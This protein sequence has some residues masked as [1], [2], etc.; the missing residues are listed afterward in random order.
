M[1]V[2]DLALKRVETSPKMVLYLGSFQR[3]SICFH[4][5]PGFVPH[6]PQGVEDF[7]PLPAQSRKFVSGIVNNC[8]QS[9][10]VSSR[11]SAELWQK[12]LARSSAETPADLWTF[13]L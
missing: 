6:P 13:G 1:R 12:T 4:I 7:I 11:L 2:A 5:H 10:T 3:I 8:N 9:S